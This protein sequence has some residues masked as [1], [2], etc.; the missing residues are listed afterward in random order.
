VGWSYGNCELIYEDKTHVWVSPPSLGPDSFDWGMAFP[1]QGWFMARWALD[2]VG[3][4]DETFNLSM[5]FD[6]CIRLNAAG[7][8]SCHVPDTIARFYIH[9]E[10]KTGTSNYADFIR[11]GARALRKAGRTVPS[12]MALGQACAQLS[13][14][15][16]RVAEDRLE[17]E[18]HAVVAELEDARPENLD[19]LA[20]GAF[21]RAAQLECKA[22]ESPLSALRWLFKPVVWR[23][24]LTRRLMPDVIKTSLVRWAE[25]SSV[26]FLVVRLRRR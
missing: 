9:S 8:R 16:A 2:Q 20:A 24:T 25:R 1:Q 18:R 21:A 4:L 11:E 7:I 23:F 26:R 15:G 13:F 12:Y 5:D 19:A 3:P 14:D 10:S 22:S 6:L 17:R